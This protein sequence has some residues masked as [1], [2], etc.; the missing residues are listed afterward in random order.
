MSANVSLNN[1][2]GFVNC[3]IIDDEKI[4][5]SIL[6]KLYKGF[7]ISFGQSIIF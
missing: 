3:A 6:L 4:E 2:F 5:Y 1:L 7:S